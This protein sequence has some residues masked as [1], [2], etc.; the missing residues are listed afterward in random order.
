ML[1]FRG[2]IGVTSMALYFRALQL[3]PVGSAISLRYL[4]PFFAG[5]LA[6]WMLHEKMKNIQWLYYTMA[7]VG[8]ILLKGFDPRISFDGLLII[9]A[10]AFF[11]GAVYVIIRKIGKSEHPATV[12]NYFMMV[13][14]IVGGIG[15]LISWVSPVGIEWLIVGGMGV[16]GFVAQFFMTKALQLAETSLI[17]PFKYTEV[18]FTVIAGWLILSEYQ[19]WQALIGICIIIAALVGNFLSRNESLRRKAV[20][21]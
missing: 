3:M 11:S 6:I 4:S 10:S 13:A 21:K 18:I 14:S 16:F 7:F 17:V 12:V 8:I 15:C 9:L 2:V 1:I 19:T 20:S 5:A